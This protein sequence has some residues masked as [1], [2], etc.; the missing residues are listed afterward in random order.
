MA[1]ASAFSGKKISIHFMRPVVSQ[2]MLSFIIA[3]YIGIVLNAVVWQH[4]LAASTFPSKPHI[5]ELVASLICVITFT[6]LLLSI[7]SFGGHTVFRVMATV[8]LLFSAAASYYMSLFNVVIGYGIMMA[9]LTTEIDLSRESVGWT[10]LLWLIPTAL[11]PV[12]A[13]W[14]VRLSHTT[15]TELR[16]RTT[17]WRPLA[18]LA[19][20]ALVMHGAL[21][22]LQHNATQHSSSQEMA[23]AGGML[24]HRYLPSNWIAGL[25][26]VGYHEFTEYWQ[27][28]PL[29][30][31]AKHFTYL[32]DPER[33]DTT[34]IFV[35]GETTRSDH[36][37]LL[38][39]ERNTT[40]LLAQEKQLV[41]MRGHACDT[42]TYLS[43][44]CMF[45]REGGTSNDNARVLKER[46]VFATLKAL[47]FSSEL[48][49]MQSEIW[50]YNSINANNY[51]LREMIA[52]APGNEGKPVDDMLL[53]PLLADS[54]SS[55]PQ[56]AQQP[57]L[58]ILHTKGSHYLYSQRYPRSFAHYTP[59]CFSIDETC[60]KQQ[61]V[62]AFDNSILYT[63]TFL[64]AVIDQVRNRKAIVF[65]SADHGESIAD[66]THF[67]ATPR[68][69][70]PPEQRRIPVM[71]WMSDALTA[72]HGGQHAYRQ[73]QARAATG[74]LARHEELFDSILGCTGFAS[75]DGGINERNNWCH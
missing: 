69:V 32:I 1:I 20:L 48:F 63:D 52:A 29:F 21:E 65:Y 47:G 8:M 59:E 28:H 7:A 18:Y 34:V 46:N 4:Q 13:L 54:L 49:S 16:Q 70:A 22:R 57:H 53:I 60:S 44:R 73:L 41:A 37:G 14:R 11:I 17:F 5:V 19:V 38:G 43:L 31:P 15:L 40:P 68:H 9:V 33:A 50:F 23:S 67:H 2:R 45:V 12:A 74:K 25:G 72:T 61:L 58:V 6:L 30:D 56:Q 51:L 55:H 62:N 75:P 24:A 35:I 10:F 39:Y 71:V 3:I 27:P 64:K 36:V 66:G 42:S 26:M